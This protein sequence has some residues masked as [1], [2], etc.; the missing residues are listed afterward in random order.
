MDQ[1]RITRSHFSF[2]AFIFGFLAG[3]LA[4]SFVSLAP[5]VAVFFI[6]IGWAVW[7]G[8]KIYKKENFL[9]LI[10][11]ITLISFGLGVLRYDIKDF[12]EVREPVSSGVIVSEPEYRDNAT[13]FILLSDNGEKALVSTDLYSRVRYGDRVK[14]DA[15]FRRPEVIEDFNYPAY[16]AK[17]DIYYTASFAEV[18][19]VSSGHGN[20]VREML[21]KIKH[22]FVRKIR[23]IFAEPEASLLA[24][25]ILAGKDAMPQSILEEFRRAGL[26]HIVVLSGYNLTI[27]A[28]FIRRSLYFLSLH[29]SS[30]ASVG[31][32]FLFILMTG[33]EP[34]VVRAGIMVFAAILGKSL[35]RHYSAHRALLLAAFIMVLFNPKILVFDP[36]FQLSFLATLA[37]IYASP[38]VER[39]I[40]K[41]PEKWGLRGMLATTLATQAVVLPYL[42]YNMGEVSLVS[43]LSNVLVLLFIPIT[44]LVGFLA[45]ILSFIH[46]LI[47]LPVA[48]IAHLLLGYTL[49]ISGFLGNLPS[50]SIEISHFPVWAA[51]LCYAFM[52]WFIWRVRNFPH[53]S[54]S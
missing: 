50:A 3:V 51:A 53:K 23:E 1:E 16:L 11:S 39:K 21:L 52:I 18:E 54:A 27:I 15:K 35:G 8:E 38:L 47:A 29:A 24:G 40:V 32:I 2:I 14:V 49:F 45:V 28:E 4:S 19:T 36:S 6:L 26:V 37:L 9:P 33:A 13:R 7:V 22:G 17:D 41:V 48:Y 42:V 10:I 12:H 5:L 44:M 43:I 20:P 31:A 46:I 25:L 34:T 30:L